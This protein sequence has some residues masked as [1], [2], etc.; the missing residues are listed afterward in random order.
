MTSKTKY[1]K[2]KIKR[3]PLKECCRQGSKHVF[4]CLDNELSTII[5]SWCGKIIF[6]FQHEN[7]CLGLVLFG[8]FFFPLS[9]PL[10]I[11]LY[12]LQD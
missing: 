8:L 4:K 11:W 12:V 5:K 6:L 9:D 3:F 10:A 2:C 1:V 7:N